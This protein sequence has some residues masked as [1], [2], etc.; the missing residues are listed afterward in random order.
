MGRF[1]FFD[2]SMYLWMREL[3][4]YAGLLLSPFVVL[5]ALTGIFFAHSWNPFESSATAEPRTRTDHVD[6]PDD[7]EPLAL[8]QEAIRQLEIT[9]EIR[10]N[11]NGYPVSF[12]VH[13][14]GRE[15][16]IQL[17]QETGKVMLTER[18]LDAGELMAYLHAAPGPHGSPEVK[19]N[20]AYTQLWGW[21]AD[22]VVYMIL[23][24]SAGGIYLWWTLRAIRRTGGFWFALGVAS[25]GGL[26]LWLL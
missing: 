15:I 17:E 14:P 12:S 24:L 8:A 2:R 1:R 13:R 19:K 23:F 5:F 7:G 3:H 10:V 18:A 22:G 20:W 4:L 26:A 21:V 6:L 11:P 25:F 16:R 9:G